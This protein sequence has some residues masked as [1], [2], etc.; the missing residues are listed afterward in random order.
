MDSTQV[1]YCA[2][3]A[4]TIKLWSV[5]TLQP[6]RTETGQPSLSRKP[7]SNQGELQSF[8]ARDQETCYT[9]VRFTERNL[10]LAAGYVNV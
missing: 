10:L 8:A 1:G 9:T 3:C 7:A 4:G 2:H 6:E 5:D